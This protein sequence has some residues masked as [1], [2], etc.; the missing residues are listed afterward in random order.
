MITKN[1]D[2]ILGLL[3]RNPFEIYN[4]NQISKK[5]K[6]SIGSA[7]KIVKTLEAKEILKTQRLGNAIYY[8]LNFLNKEAQK[9]CEL[10]LLEDKGRRLAD[11]SIAK[12]YT[13][14]IEQ[15][16]AKLTILFGSILTKKR[17]ANDVDVL[18][19]VDKVDVAEVSKFCLSLSKLKTKPVV[20]L[21]MT[22]M[23][24]KSKLKKRDKVILEIIRTGI[25]LS[26]E[27][28]FVGSLG[29]ENERKTS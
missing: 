8:K 21:I 10:I 25:I 3:L 9:L 7:H 11:N 17:G 2:K 14:D 4:V 5:L 22:L 1:S 23:D 6:I 13:H 27:E 24:F 28:V 12:V 16:K 20:P 15:F 19:I 26:G 29:D 18:F